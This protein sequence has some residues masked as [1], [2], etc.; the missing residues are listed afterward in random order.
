MK[1]K[2]KH[3]YQG[4]GEGMQR[5][6]LQN[7]TV[8]IYGL[9]ADQTTSAQQQQQQQQNRAVGCHYSAATRG[10]MAKTFRDASK[11]KAGLDSFLF[12]NRAHSHL[13][14]QGPRVRPCHE[15][16]AVGKPS[17]TPELGVRTWTSFSPRSGNGIQ[18]VTAFSAVLW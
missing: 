3:L 17:H 12:Q 13:T 10:V 15:A 18:A 7:R 2:T 6:E 16:R 9:Q 1:T 8:S 14:P 5:M 11:Q 4:E